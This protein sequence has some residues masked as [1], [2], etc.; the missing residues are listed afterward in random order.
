MIFLGCAQIQS[1]V[2]IIVYKH[3]K[4]LRP[5]NS[6]LLFTEMAMNKENFSMEEM[7]RVEQKEG[8]KEK[9]TGR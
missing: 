1:H 4:Y 7:Q 2:F 9:E 3:R 8:G 6:Y 5:L